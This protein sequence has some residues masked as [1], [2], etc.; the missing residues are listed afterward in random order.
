MVSGSRDAI[1][2]PRREELRRALARV[3][4]H[5]AQLETALDPAHASFTGK[6][7]WVG[8]AARTFAEELIGRRNRLR[9]L[10]GRIVEE[11]EAEFRATSETTD[12]P[13]GTR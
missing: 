11:L 3:R 9:V 7:V 8:P 13:A 10:V 6:A 12:R 5:A 1:P 4:L 2:N